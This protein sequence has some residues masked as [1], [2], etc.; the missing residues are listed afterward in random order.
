[1]KVNLLFKLSYL[2]SNFTLTLGYLN[3]TL[4]NLAQVTIRLRNWTIPFKLSRLLVTHDGGKLSWL[5]AGRPVILGIGK[6]NNLEQSLSSFDQKNE[7]G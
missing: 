7:F 3:T 2:N 5:P 6:I 4:N 1:M